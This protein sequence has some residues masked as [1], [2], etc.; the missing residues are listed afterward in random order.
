MHL[1][2]PCLI[3]LAAC[4][5]GGGFPDAKQIDAPPTG[6][7]SAVWSVVD[8]DNA[9]ISCDRIAGQTMTVLAHNTA[10]EGGSTQLF[11]CSTGMGTS[12]DIVAGVYDLDFELAGTFGLYARAGSQLGVPVPAGTNT[13]LQPLVFKVQA[14]GALALNLTTGKP[15]GNCGPTNAGGA[16]IDGVT[17]TLNHN[18]DTTCAPITLTIATTARPGGTYTIDCNTPVTFGCIEADQTISASGVPSDGYTIHVTGKIGTKSCYI[19]NDTIQVPPLDITLMR[20]L[21]LALNAQVGG[22]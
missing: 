9:P 5:G 4:G 21:N 16:G 18:S 17:I 13:P 1:M 22:C 19:N 20:T 10:F 8:Q 6:T 11:T 7:F 3:L 15:G 12:Q 2:R 14:T